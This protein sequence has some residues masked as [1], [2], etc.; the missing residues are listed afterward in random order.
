MSTHITKLV[1][2]GRDGI[3]NRY[4]ED[5]VKSPEQ[6]VAIEGAIEAVARL[7]HGGW[8]TVVATNQAGIGR[9]AIDM[10]SLNAIHLEMNR[11]MMREGARV[12]AVFFCPHTPEQGCECRKPLPG[13]ML[14]IARRY[15]VDLH[16]VPMVCDTLRDLLAAQAA[17]CPPHL[18]LCGRAANFG[19]DELARI[20]AHVPDTRMHASLGAFAEALLADAAAQHAHAHGHA[21]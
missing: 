5:H 19:H 20:R 1:I 14:D 18:V 2:L 21:A 8:H 13:M 9:G 4:R 6:W 12:D 3:L 11:Q 16:Q 7:N 15:A 17:G 10:A